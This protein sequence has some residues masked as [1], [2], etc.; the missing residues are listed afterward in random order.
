MR[1]TD[2]TLLGG[3]LRYAQPAD[4]YRTGGEPVLLAAAIPARNGDR[5]LEAGAGAGAG[6]M[7]L[8]ARVPGVTGVAIERDPDM[9]A[10]AAA[11]FA[12]NGFAQLEAVEADLLSWRADTLFDHAFANPPWHDAAGTASPVPRRRAAMQGQPGLLETW[13]GAMARLLKPRGTLSLILPAAS[14]PQALRSLEAA[15]CGGPAVLP[16]WPR[17]G[18]A[19]KLLILQGKYQARG[20]ARLLA[21]LTL[22]EGTGYTQAAEAVL[23]LGDAISI[24]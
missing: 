14:L 9:A 21:G 12:A 22:H 15:H 2:A 19:A 8:A 20:Q 18:V 10:L 7:C 3:R 1:L 4:G 11:N 17:A 13:A 6:L 24:T 16:L 23:R 5:V